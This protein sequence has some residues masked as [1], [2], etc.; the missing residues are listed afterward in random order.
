MAKIHLTPQQLDQAVKEFIKDK[1]NLETS[2][3]LTYHFDIESQKVTVEVEVKS[4]DKI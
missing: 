4:V 1:F 2:G 3:A